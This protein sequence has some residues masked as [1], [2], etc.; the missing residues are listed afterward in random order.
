VPVARDHG[1]PNGLAGVDHQRAGGGDSRPDLGAGDVHLILGQQLA[2]AREDG[3]AELRPEGG[4]E[5]LRVGARERL[6]GLGVLLGGGGVVDEGLQQVAIG[7]LLRGVQPRHDGLE[8][9]ARRDRGDVADEVATGEVVQLSR[10]L[11]RVAQQRRELALQAGLRGAQRRADAA[12]GRALLSG[13]VGAG[14][15]GERLEEA[16]RRPEDAGGEGAALLDRLRARVEGGVGVVLDRL[17]V[18]GQLRVELVDLVGE[19]V[20]E[21]DVAGVAGDGEDVGEPAALLDERVL[22]LLEQAADGVEVGHPT[23]AGQA[24]EAIQV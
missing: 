6:D 19:A 10:L 16:L 20:N 5:R 2:G 8:R 14:A 9:R 4:G 3:R 11:G 7:L 1:G 12:Q 23:E 17:R 13:G 22:A 21:V 15:L 24:R 18:L